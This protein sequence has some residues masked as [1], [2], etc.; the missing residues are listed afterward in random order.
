MLK[1]I[2]SLSSIRNIACC[3]RVLSL[4]SFSLKF[5]AQPAVYKLRDY[6]QVAFSSH[7]QFPKI[8]VRISRGRFPMKTSKHL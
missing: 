1:N 4:E 3:F 2:N 6:G 5:Q 8:Q 7:L